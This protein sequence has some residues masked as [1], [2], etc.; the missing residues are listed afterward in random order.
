MNEASKV[1]HEYEYRFTSTPE[2]Q[3]IDDTW[4]FHDVL[5]KYSPTGSSVFI[6]VFRKRMN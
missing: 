3:V 2:Y 6:T 5:I 4:E 1:I